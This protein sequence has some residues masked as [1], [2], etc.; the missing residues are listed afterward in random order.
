MRYVSE[1]LEESGNLLRRLERAPVLSLLQK[2]MLNARSIEDLPLA[3][4][5]D[6][7]DSVDIKWHL[8]IDTNHLH[9]FQIIEKT[10]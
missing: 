5:K 4:S 9:F 8:S 1:K 7:V 10:K 2:T 3:W 6:S